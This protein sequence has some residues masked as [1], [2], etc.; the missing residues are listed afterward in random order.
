MISILTADMPTESYVTA[1][2]PSQ[3][4]G[5]HSFV[6][7]CVSIICNWIR[8]EHNLFLSFNTT[9]NGKASSYDHYSNEHLK[10]ANKNFMFLCQC[11]ALYT[12]RL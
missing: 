11:Y 10:Y 9:P 5:K 2:E 1:N 8:I 12:S 6:F 4:L 3:F 7:V